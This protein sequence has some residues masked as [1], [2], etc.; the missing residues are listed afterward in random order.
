MVGILRVRL[1]SIYLQSRL[2][3][4]VDPLVLHG[5]QVQLQD[6]HVRSSSGDGLARSGDQGLEA[7]LLDIRESRVGCSGR[8]PGIQGESDVIISISFKSRFQLGS[9]HEPS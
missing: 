9:N 2:W 5:A 7:L 6:H 4:V 8:V 1:C 3:K